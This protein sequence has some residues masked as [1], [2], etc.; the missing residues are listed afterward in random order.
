[1]REFDRQWG[2]L[3]TRWGRDG[4]AALSRDE[5]VWLNVGSLIV[6]IYNGGLISFFYN[7]GADTYDDCVE[8]LGRIGASEVRAEVERVGSLFPGG[9]STSLEARNAV[10]NAWAEREVD[11]FLAEVDG[12]LMPLMEALETKLAAFVVAAGLARRE[13]Q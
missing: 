3:C 7:S 13:N 11:P 2:E 5:R 4:Y 1:M 9:V 8:A 6:A 12:V 10:I